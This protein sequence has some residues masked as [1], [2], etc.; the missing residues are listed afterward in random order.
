MKGKRHGHEVPTM[1][2]MR[3]SVFVYMCQ[4]QSEASTGFIATQSADPVLKSC[5]EHMLWN[6]ELVS[7]NNVLASG[8]Y[9]LWEGVETTWGNQNFRFTLCASW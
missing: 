1:L 3:Q 7:W 5:A 2:I 8:W 4:Y 6:N 9:C